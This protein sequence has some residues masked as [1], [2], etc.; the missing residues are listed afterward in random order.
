MSA[1]VAG[2][3]AGAGEDAGGGLGLDPDG[4]D[5]GPLRRHSYLAALADDMIDRFGGDTY[6][7]QITSAR[8]VYDQRRGRVFEDEPLWETW[9]QA[10]LEWYVTEHPMA[11]DPGTRPPAAEIALEARRAGDHRREAAAQAWLCSHRSLFEVRGLRG[12]RV[13]VVDLVGGGQFS[14]REERALAG[15]SVGD[16]AELRLVGFEDEVVFGRTFCFHPAGTRDAI[17]AHVHRM[18]ASHASRP[19]MV[20]FCASLRIRCERYRHVSPPR[21]YAGTT[22]GGD[23]GG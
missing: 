9:T 15:V 7:E 20:D 4:R 22:P 5:S 2:L 23:R 6:T 8:Q 16:V 17:T 11:G 13:T 19:D 1:P 21:I 14:V 12:G 10:F 3:S 18:R